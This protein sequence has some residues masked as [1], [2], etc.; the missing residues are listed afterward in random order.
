MMS[1][2]RR[3]LTG[4]GV[5]ALAA[6]GPLV[7][8]G[9]PVADAADVD[10]P[11]CFWNNAA[12]YGYSNVAYPDTAATYWR[13]DATLA[14]GS[15]LEFTATYP[16]A[17]YF[18]YNLYDPQLRPIDG[19]RDDLLV[20]D[21]GSTN[22]YVVGAD[23][24]VTDRSYTMR[25]VEGPAPAEA[26][27]EANT[28]YLESDV[29]TAAPNAL[30]LYR[31]YVPDDATRGDDGLRVDGGA[32]PT[33]VQHFAD[34][35][36]ADLTAGCNDE[37][38]KRRESSRIADEVDEY[39]RNGNASAPAIATAASPTL[40]WEAFFN[41][42]HIKL[43]AATG[44]TAVEPGLTAAGGYRAAETAFGRGG[45]LS[46]R[47]N[48]YGL[49]AGHR[50][51]GPILLLEGRA[52]TVPRTIDG[53]AT[54]GGGDLR[55]WSI[56]TNEQQTTRS[57]A[58]LYDNQFDVDADGMFRLVISSPNDRPD[59]YLEACGAQWLAWGLS[60]ETVVI[61][62]HMVAAPGFTSTIANV[63]RAREGY[64]DKGP[65]TIY[66][67]L[68][69]YLPVGTHHASEAD[70]PTCNPASTAGRASPRSVETSTMR[71][72]HDRSEA[73]RVQWRLGSPNNG[74]RRGLM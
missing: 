8:V 3:A 65:G 47:D 68:G 36:T 33:V 71:R 28:L 22:P 24:T 53:Q 51:Y 16:E 2:A 9:T 43:V 41:L 7:G 38:P 12:G 37:T 73:P 27:R 14:P 54:M 57:V 64:D 74:C 30:M 70:L 39:N 17:R 23:R 34:G 48:H 61:L 60:P 44:G 35:S 69:D 32:L 5:A 50:D 10:S 42:P 59:A 26:D 63:E 72:C 13:A 1:K 55:Y 19:I 58:C 29:G 66:D 20:P 62:R 6:A 52:P 56:C 31:V 15:Y 4:I 18:S 45:Y 40:E 67:V 21:A 46:N 25:I 11:R 49:A